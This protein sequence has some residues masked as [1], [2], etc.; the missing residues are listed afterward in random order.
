MSERRGR[1]A[2]FAKYYDFIYEDLLD[3]DAD[4]RYLEAV[5]RR[6]LPGKPRT[7]LDLG[8][9]TGNHAIRLARR[10]YEVTGLDRSRDQLAI[11]IRKARAAHLPV[12]FVAG[13]MRSFRLGERFGA[14]ICMFG[15]FGY[16]RS[17]PAA[18]QTLRTVR[19]HLAPGGL[20]GFEFWQ[21]SAARPAPYLAWFHKAGTEFELVRLD[22]ARY[23]PRT[24]LLPIDFQFFV[25][26]G[27]R[28]VDRFAET[29]TVRTFHTEE[30]RRLL[31]RSGFR[32]AGM[33]GIGA[34][35]KKGFGRVRKDSFRVF[36]VGR[37][38]P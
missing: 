35:S 26:K 7:I 16:V 14:T 25:F 21:S 4:V 9:G 12:R 18:L 19:N 2:R 32:V 33:F 37:S 29:H 20:F 10:G 24:R 11:A 1:Y 34:R 3:Y 23:E 28:V 8:C 5:F 36:A 38:A 15:A 27:Q 31:G 22:T 6:F 30:V 17:I 13:D